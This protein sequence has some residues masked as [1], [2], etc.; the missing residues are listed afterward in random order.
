MVVE[1]WEE[2]PAVEVYVVCKRC[3]RCTG[4]EADICIRLVGFT[5]CLCI[6]RIDDG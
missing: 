1:R 5:V 6:D 2:L 3:G 4:G